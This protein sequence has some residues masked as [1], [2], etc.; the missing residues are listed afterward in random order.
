MPRRAPKSRPD[1]EKKKDRT[2]CSTD[3][4]LLECVL[5]HYFA[6]ACAA[7][8]YNIYDVAKW[9]G[10]ANINV[11]Y[12]TYMHLFGGTRDMAGLDALTPEAP[13]RAIPTIG[14]SLGS[15]G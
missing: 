3:P 6:S 2:R 1:Y 4:V 8:N 10:H 13:T 14:A 15:T 5:R 9:M 7:A 11:T 12:S